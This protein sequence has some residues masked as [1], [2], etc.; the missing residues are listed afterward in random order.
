MFSSLKAS[1]EEESKK[2]WKFANLT[3]LLI[4]NELFFLKFYMKGTFHGTPIKAAVCKFR[5]ILSI[6]MYILRS[7]FKCCLCSRLVRYSIYSTVVARNI[8]VCSV[9]AICI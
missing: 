7:S 9:V 1:G 4:L 6:R 5:C 2:N 8:D 3:C